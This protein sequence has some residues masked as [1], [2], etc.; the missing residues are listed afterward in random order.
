M[1]TL[2]LFL[3]LALMII[4]AMGCL[5][6]MQGCSNN[7]GTP[8]LPVITEPAI[9]DNGNDNTNLVFDDELPGKPPEF[10]PGAPPI[11]KYD[12]ITPLMKI[13]DVMGVPSWRIMQETY[14]WLGVRY[15]YGGNSRSGID[16]S[17]LVYQVYRNVGIPYPY[18]TT[19]TMRTSSRFIC[20]NPAPGDI[21]LFMN[22]NHCG[23]YVGNGWMIDANSYYGKV[24]YDYI[25]DSYWS[26]M[27]PIAIRFVR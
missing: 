23:V 26:A 22:I 9:E 3:A 1:K 15:L 13:S 14:T 2:K 12:S 20:V 4:A 5:M 7:D 25:W 6:Y 16:C 19:S 11:P 27:R 24:R 18:M 10:Y 17:H 8:N 21:I